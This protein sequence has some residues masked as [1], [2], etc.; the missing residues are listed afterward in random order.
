MKNKF[1]VYVETY[2]MLTVDYFLVMELGVIYLLFAWLYFFFFFFC[3]KPALF[4]SRKKGASF[5]FI[6]F[7]ILENFK[8]I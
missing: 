7:L 8:Q 5:P 1:D 3:N 4:N 6:F 2:Q